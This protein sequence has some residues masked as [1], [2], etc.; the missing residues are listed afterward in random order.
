[1][2]AFNHTHIPLGILRSAAKRLGTTLAAGLVIAAIASPPAAA[3]KENTSFDF[4]AWFKGLSGMAMPEVKI[5]IVWASN[6]SEAGVPIFKVSFVDSS[7]MA[8]E[9]LR[10]GVEWATATGLTGYGIG[11]ESDLII[12]KS[13]RQSVGFV[14]NI[15]DDTIAH[16]CNKLIVS[17]RSLE[18]DKYR[19]APYAKGQGFEY[20]NYLDND[21]GNPSGT[22]SEYCTNS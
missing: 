22:L 15:P 11:G 8:T 20:V 16:S 21:G 19:I 6:L 10:I 13:D 7:S 17:L 4:D 5:E 1:M 14:I 2:N 18:P 3:E 12:P 9:D